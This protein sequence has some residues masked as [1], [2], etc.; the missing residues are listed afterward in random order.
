MPGECTIE[1]FTFRGGYGP[2]FNG[3]SSAG[4][5]LCNR[6]APTIRNCLFI[7]NTALA[8]GAAYAYQRPATFINCT[9]VN[10]S[11]TLR[12]GG[13]CDDAAVATFENCI[14]ADNNQGQPV[15]CLEGGASASASCTNIFGNAG[16]D[17]VGCLSGQ[18]SS[19]NNMSA[20]PLFC[21][22]VSG[23][24]RLQPLSPCAPENNGC[25]TLIGA[26]DVG[27][28]CDCSSYCDLD[29]ANGINPLDVT[30]LV[31][32][33]FRSLD[34]RIQTACPGD[35]GDWNCDGLITP[36]DVTW[37]VQFVF[38]YSGVGPCDPCACDPYPGGCPPFP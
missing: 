8:G 30:I 13:F 37:S 4:G 9:F 1:G 3:V 31:N 36:L 23:N 14:I 19:N 25:L 27:C 28:L 16:G 26:L 34:S 29:L 21:D 7:D 15:F 35:E 12:C 6:A 11:A 20:D 38:R 18:E 2:Y 32:Y 10:N 22:A 17:W 24:C 33:V 5:L